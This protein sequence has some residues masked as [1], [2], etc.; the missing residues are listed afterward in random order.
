MT[1]HLA[2]LSLGLILVGSGPCTEPAPLPPELWT[3]ER[4]SPPEPERDAPSPQ[5]AQQ[6][7]TTRTFM[8]EHSSDAVN[9][10]TGA[11]GGRLDDVHRAASNIADDPWSPRLRDDY[12]RHLEVTRRAARAALDAT[13]IPAATSALGQL[14]AACAGC[15]ED[16]GGPR[17]TGVIAAPALGDETM[18]A[19]AAA[20]EAL[21]QGLFLPSEASWLRGARQLAS[22][23]ALDS[24][25]SEVSV[26]AHRARTL[27]HAAEAAPRAARGDIYGRILATCSAC[28]SRLGVEP[29]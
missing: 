23:P 25:V 29:M 15:H 27:A 21:W 17:S 14:G 12:R 26:L 7:K 3:A 20:E 4:R 5:A 11:M 19:H 28:H 1:S 6:T 2:C 24:D 22:A 13:T 9:M 16:V 8:H 10:R 18:I